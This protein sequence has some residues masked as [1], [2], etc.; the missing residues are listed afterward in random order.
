MK[1]GMNV[2]KKLN[3]SSKIAENIV[4]E[5]AHR[6]KKKGNGAN[7]EKPR[8]IVGRFLDYKDKTNIL[9]NAKKLKGK[10]IFINADFSH[11]TMEL[12][13][14]LWEKVKKHRDKCKTAYLHYRTA[15]VKQRN[16]QGLS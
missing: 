13:K 1:P 10:N 8:T 11:V 15:V 9:K 3:Y 7:P 5:R 2:S 16:N 14:G 6:I 12:R 4:T